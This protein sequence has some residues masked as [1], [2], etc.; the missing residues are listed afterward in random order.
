MPIVGMLSVLTKEDAMNHRFSDLQAVSQVISSEISNFALDGLIVGGEYD[1]SHQV[2]LFSSAS[3][4]E[5]Y[6]V[7]IK[8]LN[9]DINPISPYWAGMIHEL[10]RSPYKPDEGG[11]WMY[12][13][14]IRASKYLPEYEGSVNILHS[15]LMSAQQEYEIN[16][17]S[18]VSMSEIFERQCVQKAL[19]DVS[20]EQLDYD[21]AVS[22]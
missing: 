21:M 19:H 4:E 8:I 12:A 17:S 11:Y 6:F 15:L 9:L 14:T 1:I 13:K 2:D 22:Q 16:F 7:D 5:K 10:C 18:N 20:F 3:E